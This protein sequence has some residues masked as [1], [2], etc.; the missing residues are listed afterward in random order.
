MS[1]LAFFR[2][3]SSEQALEQFLAGAERR[4][5]QTALLTTR[6]E[7]DA[8]DIVQDAMLQLVQHY[9]HR[10]SQEWPKLM[11]R[12][13][14][15]R[16]VD[17]VRQ[18]QIQKGRFAMVLEDLEEDPLN[19]V[20][21]PKDIN[22]LSLLSA[23]Q[24]IQRVLRALEALPLRQRQCFLLRAWEG[25]D[26]QATAEALGISTGSVKT[27]YARSLDKLTQALINSQPAEVAYA[28]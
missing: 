26:T 11:Q 7:A 15:N 14:Q 12:I 20:A 24:D 2:R 21:D 19:Q 18:Q 28:T 27:H 10:D 13:L 8:L 4:A 1:V 9:R 17:W 16:I 25:F 6:R 5:Y 23:Q 22:P 3:T